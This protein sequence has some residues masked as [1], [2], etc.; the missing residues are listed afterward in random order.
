MD[1]QTALTLCC[2]ACG[3]LAQASCNCGA[4]YEPLSRS[5]NAERRRERVIELYKTGMTQQQIADKLKVD[6]KTISRDLEG[7]GTMPKPPRPK[8]GRPRAR[9][10]PKQRRRT[11][12]P[13]QEEQAASLVLDQGKTYEQTVAEAGLKSPTTVKTSV[14]REEGRRE[15]MDSLLDA[16]AVKNFTDKGVL[17]IEDAIRI[18]KARLEKQFEQRVNDEVRKRIDAADNAARAQCKKLHLENISLMRIVQ[19]HGVFTET[20]YRQML[21]LCHPDNSAG[22]E[23]KATLLQV[24]V[25]NKIKLI[26]S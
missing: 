25:E 1:A 13:A 19:Q 5:Q 9:G 14:A 20:Q 7:L 11:T 6:Q 4:G 22:P 24:L 18:H 2:T 17:R 3:A 12:T 23:I 26:K 8:G 21:M 15:L 16:A 10:A